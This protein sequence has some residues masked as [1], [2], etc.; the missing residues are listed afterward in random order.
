MILVPQ[1][2]KKEN[3]WFGRRRHFP[4]IKTESY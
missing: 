2:K 1:E 3:G 4:S